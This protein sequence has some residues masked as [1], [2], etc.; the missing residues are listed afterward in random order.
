MR[1]REGEN[2][3]GNGT[4]KRHGWQLRTGMT[5]NG[6]RPVW[7]AHHGIL[8]QRMQRDSDICMAWYSSFRTLHVVVFIDHCSR[9]S[10]SPGYLSFLLVQTIAAYDCC[11]TPWLGLLSFAIP[12]PKLMSQMHSFLLTGNLRVVESPCSHGQ[13]RIGQGILLCGISCSLSS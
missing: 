1:N 8:I 4:A 10:L 9:S 5:Q 2:A 6:S 7:L 11:I 13:P 12:L 3:I